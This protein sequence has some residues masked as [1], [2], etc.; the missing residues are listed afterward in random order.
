MT[1]SFLSRNFRVQCLCH[2]LAPHKRAELCIL[3]LLGVVRQLAIFP[4]S[5]ANQVSPKSL[6]LNVSR[7]L[8]LAAVW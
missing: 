3:V 4:P 7:K 2:A 1:A 6:W 5:S 8:T